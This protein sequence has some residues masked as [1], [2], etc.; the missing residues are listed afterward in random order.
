MEDD[1]GTNPRGGWARV[2]VQEPLLRS[3]QFGRM[4]ACIDRSRQ[5]ASIAR[6]YPRSIP[7]CRQRRRGRRDRMARGCSP[8]G[9]GQEVG[10]EC[11]DRHHRARHFGRLASHPGAAP[12]RRAATGRLPAAASMA[13]RLASPIA[14]ESWSPNRLAAPG[15]R[16]VALRGPVGPASGRSQV[17]SRAG[18]TAVVRSPGPALLRIGS[19]ALGQ[20]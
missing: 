9:S 4:L 14:G 10:H 20:Q 19:A 3:E 5:A 18:P 11:T 15:R 2:D 7:P 6:G 8:L 17:R 1:V 12:A 13:C 16:V